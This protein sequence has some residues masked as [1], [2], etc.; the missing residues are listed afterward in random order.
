MF[1][2][3]GTIMGKCRSQDDDHFWSKN[4]IQPVGDLAPLEKCAILWTN[5]LQ[6]YYKYITLVDNLINTPKRWKNTNTEETGKM[7][8]R[9]SIPSA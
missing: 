1:R 7:A 9:W 3:A 6:I 4:E 2:R 5:I 8:L